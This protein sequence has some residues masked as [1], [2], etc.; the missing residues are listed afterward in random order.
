MA[1]AQTSAKSP[2]ASHFTP[3]SHVVIV[4][5]ENHAYQDIIGS[6]LAPYI[7]SLAHSGASFTNSF[8][9]SHP[10]LPNYLALFSGSD[11]GVTDDFCPRTFSKPTLESELIDAGKTFGGYSEGL[12]SAGSLVCK[13]DDYARKHAPWTYFA[14][15]PAANNLPFSNFPQNYDQ[16]PTISWVIP[17]LIDDMHDGTIQEADNWLKANLSGYAE[18]AQTHNSLLIIT[19]DE[20]DKDHGNQIPTIFVGGVIKQ[21]QYAEKINHYSVLRTLEDMYS[22]PRLGASAGAKPITDVWK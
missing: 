12:P 19:W 3:P 1:S 11:E 10:S 15:A 16:L 13:Q 14:N 20:D 2:F 4:M 21:G 18:W 22:L 7:N 6:P 17:N 8:A 9:I 5:E